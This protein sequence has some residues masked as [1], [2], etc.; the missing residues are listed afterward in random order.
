M[1]TKKL[2]D[3]K[4]LRS[5]FFDARLERDHM[6]RKYTGLRE[7]AREMGVSSSTLSRFISKDISLDIETI[8]KICNWLNEPINKFIGKSK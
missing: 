5:K 1:K 2:F 7:Y 6:R 4:L 8:I 3:Y